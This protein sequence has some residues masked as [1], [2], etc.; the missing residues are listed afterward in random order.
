MKVEKPQVV[1][2]VSKHLARDEGFK[3]SSLYEGFKT[4]RWYEGLKISS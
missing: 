2:N 1:I 4:S 3:T